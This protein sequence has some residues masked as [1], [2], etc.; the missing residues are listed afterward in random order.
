MSEKKLVFLIDTGS[1]ISILKAERILN[2]RVNTKRAIEIIGIA[3]SKPIQSLG[4]TKALLTCNDLIIAHDFHVMHENVFLRPDGILGADFS[5]KYNAKIDMTDPSIQLK[6]PPTQTN[7]EQCNSKFVSSSQQINRTEHAADEENYFKAVNEYLAYEG[8]IVNQIRIH[9]SKHNKNF[10]DNISDEYFLN[11]K[12][13]V[14]NPEKINI[15]PCEEMNFGSTSKPFEI[16]YASD[17]EAPLVDPFQRQKYIMD[18]IDLSMMDENQIKMISEICL[19]C[20]DA[21]YIPND[22]FKL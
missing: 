10:Y 19:E 4:I 9:S 7:G 12:L 16:K 17:T 2:A 15:Y 11:K 14:V 3:N 22:A 8:A 21:F 13:E 5:I 1:Q 18:K 6:L 20:S